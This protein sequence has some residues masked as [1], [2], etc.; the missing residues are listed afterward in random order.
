MVPLPPNTSNFRSGTDAVLDLS[1][2]RSVMDDVLAEEALKADPR[3]ADRRHYP[4]IE[5]IESKDRREQVST[6]FHSTHTK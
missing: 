6:L 3:L 5:K 2:V 1:E 4:A